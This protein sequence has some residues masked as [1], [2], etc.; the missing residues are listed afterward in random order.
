MVKASQFC[1]LVWES[2][3]DLEHY[4]RAAF[5]K[6]LDK[7]LRGVGG[8]ASKGGKKATLTEPVKSYAIEIGASL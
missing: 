7:E 5:G 6:G 1:E 2:D 8:K 4:F 3:D